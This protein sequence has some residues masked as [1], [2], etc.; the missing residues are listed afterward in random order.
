MRRWLFWALPFAL[1]PAP[2]RA[3]DTNYQDFL[4]GQRAMGMGGAFVALSDDPSASWYN[5]GGLA[6]MRRTSASASLSLYGIEHRR[7]DGGFGSP[8]RVS[9]LRQTAFPIIPTTFSVMTKFGAPEQGR[10]RNAVGLSLFLPHSQSVSFRSVVQA[11][12]EA[13]VFQLSENDRTLWVGPSFARRFGPDFAFGFSL[14]YDNRTYFRSTEISNFLL[15]PRGQPCPGNPSACSVA[16]AIDGSSGS[17]FLRLGA[18]WQIDPQW[19]LGAAFSTPNIH[20]HGGASLFSR[21]LAATPGAGG[22]VQ[23]AVEGLDDQ[24]SYNRRPF[25]LRVGGAHIDPEAVTLSFDVSFHGPATYR[26]IDTQGFIGDP[27]FVR[28]V[29]RDPVVNVNL[30]FEVLARADMPVRVGL[31]TNFSSAPEIP[32]RTPDPYLPRV[33]MFGG[34]VSVGYLGDGYGLDFGIS[35]SHGSGVMQALDP[36]DPTMLRRASA[37]NTLVYIFV[38][39]IGQALARNVR[40]LLDRFKFP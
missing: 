24:P 31:Y 8:V 26:R 29:R 22:G 5:P 15:T 11:G 23:F 2:A 38:S 33:H 3:S 30:G 25:E 35:V 6:L 32:E 20:L 37:G 27:L 7:V 36:A 18:L 13:G 4:L 14:F 19:R 21:R 16:T 12:G 17:L 28:E 1:A 9:D 39:G 34:S 10:R 40:R